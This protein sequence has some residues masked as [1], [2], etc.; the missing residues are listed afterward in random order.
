M[1]TKKKI[2]KLLA[3]LLCGC[4]AVSV[5]GCTQNVKAENEINTLETDVKTPVE[6]LEI[7]DNFKAADM[8]FSVE[9]FKKTYDYSK[10]ENVLVSPLSVYPALTMTANGADKETLSEMEKVL[11]DN[12]TIDLLNGYLSEYLNSIKAEKDVDFH[13]AN[14]IWFRETPSLEV[15][16]DFL[17]KNADYYD[18]EIY[19]APFDQSTVDKINGWVKENTHDMIPTVIDRLGDSAMMCLINALAFEAKWEEEYTDQQFHEDYFNNLDG[20]HTQVQMMTSTESDYL[21]GEDCTGFVKNYSGGKY[22]FAALLPNEDINIEDFLASLTDA[23]L[24][25]ILNSMQGNEEVYVNIPEFKCEYSTR[26]NDPLKDM[27]MPAAFDPYSSSFGKMALVDGE[28]S[29]YISDVI[30][31][32]FIEVDRK[33]TKAAAVTAVMMTEGCAI[34]EDPPKVVVLDRPFLYMILDRENNLP[35]FIGVVNSL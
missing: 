15:N 21:E 2:K 11:G 29:L 32:T 9:L 27:G 20:T 13:I 35:V 6:G 4:M 22:A 25:E 14:S 5:T 19:K 18:S 1:K 17:Q 30:H 28:D 26:L 24:S 3:L 7:D 8:K 10:G 16:K 33:G 12:L 34:D 31:K 23:K